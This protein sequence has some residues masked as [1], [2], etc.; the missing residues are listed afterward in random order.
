[1]PTRSYLSQVELPV[2]FGIGEHANVDAVRITWPDGT[3]QTLKDIGIDHMQVVHQ[4]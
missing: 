4:P 3:Q 2:T 1:M